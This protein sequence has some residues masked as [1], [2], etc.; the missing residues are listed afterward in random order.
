[1]LQEGI[2]AGAILEV[3]AESP[4]FHA[5]EEA[6]WDLRVTIVWRNSIVAMSS[7]GEATKEIMKRLFPDQQEF[8]RAERRRF[9]LIEEHADVPVFAH[10]TSRW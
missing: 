9:E 1:M 5:A 6:H 3:S 8:E 2:K 7:G 4:R 10:D